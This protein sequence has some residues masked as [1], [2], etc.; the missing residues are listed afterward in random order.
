ME[1]GILQ[2]FAGNFLPMFR[3]ICF[4]LRI[5]PH[6]SLISIVSLAPTNITQLLAFYSFTVSQQKT[7]FQSVYSIK[8]IVTSI[9]QIYSHLQ[10]LFILQFCPSRCKHPPIVNDA[11]SLVPLPSGRKANGCKWIFRI[12]QNT[13]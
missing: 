6:A 7:N 2:A 10:I 3:V 5:I 8:F 1:C 9:S 13:N 4:P 11:W 12:K